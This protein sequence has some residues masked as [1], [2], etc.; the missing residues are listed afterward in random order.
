MRRSI[1]LLWVLLILPGFLFSS[2]SFK[3]TK[4]LEV[5]KGAEYSGNVISPGGQVTINGK[6]EYSVI[7]F[8]GRLHLDGEIGEDVIC[9]GSDV[10]IGKGAVI[11]GDLYVIGGILHKDSGADIK[12]EFTYF[13]FDVKKIESTLLPMIF[14][15][16]SLTFFIIL[17]I[18]LWLLIALVVFAIVPHK[19]MNAGELLEKNS[20]KIGVL[21]L[22]SLFSFIFLI[23]ISILL[24][25]ILIGLP[26]LFLLIL[27]YFVIFLFG[28]T[29]IFF[30]IGD[31]ITQVL[32]FKNAAP[33][34]F[35]IIGALVF[36]LLKFI[37]FVGA[38]VLIIINLFE[39]GVGV[40]FLFRKK[41]GFVPVNRQ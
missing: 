9:I 36:G 8:G 32:K 7:M 26:I 28:R 17:K 31:R 10:N 19:I 22:V 33:S 27:A 34:V 3:I 15:S 41:L 38:V 18:I 12:G 40:G 37:P 16:T 30:Y 20:F 14:D 21:G 24:S 11:K 13:R 39:V 6:F 35:I 29:V 4:N 5:K 23:F 2:S 1:S 25:F